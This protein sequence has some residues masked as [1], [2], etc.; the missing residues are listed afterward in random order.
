MALSWTLLTIVLAGLVAWMSRASARHSGPHV[1]PAWE[2]VLAAQDRRHR[3]YEEH[4]TDLADELAGL[5]A[6]LSWAR[7]E[8]E[9]GDAQEAA[10]ALETAS[11]YVARHVPSLRERLSMWNDAG[12]VLSAHYPLP[13]LRVAEF[14]AWKLRGA[15]AGDGLLRPLLDAAHRFS[16]RVYVLLFGL[17]VVLVDFSAAADGDA[18]ADLEARL[19]RLEARCADLG[20]LHRAILDVYKALLVSIHAR[21]VSRRDGE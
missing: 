5:Q 17:K 21:A 7:R 14:R 11:R 10:R 16:L 19:G 3:R 18:R 6:T 15:A 1:W 12:R 9:R 20:S 4:E 13:R 8:N 2:I